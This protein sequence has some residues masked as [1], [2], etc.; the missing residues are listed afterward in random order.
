[1]NKEEAIA[2]VASYVASVLQAQHVGEII[3]HIGLGG[4]TDADTKRMGDAVEE[5]IRRLYRMGS[6]VRQ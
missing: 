2:H 1:M 6:M 3:D 5:V 4:L